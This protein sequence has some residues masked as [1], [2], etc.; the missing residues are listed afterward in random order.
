MKDKKLILYIITTLI[1][2]I[3]LYIAVGDDNILVIG[4]AGG[5][6]GPGIQQLVYRLKYYGDKKYGLKNGYDYDEMEFHLTQ[7]ACAITVHLFFIILTCICAILLIIK[8]ELYATLLATCGI[9][10]IMLLFIV[11][12]ILGFM[13]N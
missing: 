11:R 10:L 1:G 8:Y 5:L 7:K 12:I 9:G 2:F 4:L 13:N 3:A 6:L